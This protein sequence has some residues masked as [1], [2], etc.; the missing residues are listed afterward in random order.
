MEHSVVTCKQRIFNLSTLL[1]EIIWPTKFSTQSKPF[2]V[3]GDI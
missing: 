2:C 1:S 3:V